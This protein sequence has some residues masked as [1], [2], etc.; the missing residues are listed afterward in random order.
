VTAQPDQLSFIGGNNNNNGRFS[1]IGI[2]PNGAAMS[3]NQ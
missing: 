3:R 1:N 2:G